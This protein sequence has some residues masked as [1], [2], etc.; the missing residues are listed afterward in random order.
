M[1]DADRARF[2]VFAGSKSAYG[3]IDQFCQV[4]PIFSKALSDK[5]V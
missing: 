2:A 1:S 4:N 5:R 3:I